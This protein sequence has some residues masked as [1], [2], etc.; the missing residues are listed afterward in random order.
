MAEQ[1]VPS[2]PSGVQ[3]WLNVVLEE[4]SRTRFHVKRVLFEVVTGGWAH[5][6]LDFRIPAEEFV[7]LLDAANHPVYVANKLLPKLF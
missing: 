1:S 5:F 2:I 7:R 6:L 4:N 3:K